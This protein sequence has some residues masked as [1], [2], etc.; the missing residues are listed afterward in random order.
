M[1]AEQD[2]TNLISKLKVIAEG[3]RADADGLVQKAGS[4]LASLSTP[5]SEGLRYIPKPLDVNISAYATWPV[6]AGLPALATESPGSLQAI[7][8]DIPGFEGTQPSLDIPTIRPLVLDDAVEFTATAPAAPSLTINPSAPTLATLEPPETHVPQAVSAD[9][10]TG[11]APNV[12]RPVFSVFQGSVFD[13]YQEGLGLIDNELRGWMQWLETLRNQFAPAEDLLRLRVQKT[14]S[15]EETALPDDWETKTYQQGQHEA[16]VTRYQEYD[17]LDG[18]PSSSTEL[19][20]G[21][22]RYAQ[23]QLEWKAMQTTMDSAAKTL[24]ARQEAEVDH[25]QWAL[26]LI[27][28]FVT[29]ALEIKAQEA[30]WRMQGVL[31][32]LE[33][34][35]ETLNLA[36]QLLE[37]KQKELELLTRYNDTQIR[38]MEDHIKIEKTKLESLKL[39]VESNRLNATYN[40]QQSEIYTVATRLVNN[41]IEIFDQR[42]Q[43]LKTK[44]ELEKTKLEVFA[45]EVDVHRAKASAKTAEYRALRAKIDG[46]LVAVEG[47]MA[48][49]RLY[50]AEVSAKIAEVSSATAKVQAQIAQNRSLLQQH[51]ALLSAQTEYL[52]INASH[53]QAGVDAVG[54]QIVSQAKQEELAIS[55]AEL[56]GQE[57]LNKELNDLQYDNLK[58]SKE[59]KQHMIRLSQ[60]STQ[61]STINNGANTLSS[62][63]A[64]AFSG[65]NGVAVTQFVE[66]M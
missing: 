37:Y 11:V 62:I 18:L 39:E 1:S 28:T 29:V 14:L 40:E 8:Q 51:N 38:R 66:A 45:A 2:V 22:R 4:D 63:A 52:N 21:E 6:E 3:Y 7:D 27:Q 57:G 20:T 64:T 59:L 43:L 31:L 35:N 32:A 10:I 26:E 25:V 55:E 56:A 23:W 44:S 50:E 33:G 15:G 53:V 41:K 12:P 49:V 54:K 36:V 24:M 61:A 48:K 42:I 65:M 5:R 46:D 60:I 58:L 13:E 16:A 19:P 9:P 30:T 17:Q 34:A 47:E